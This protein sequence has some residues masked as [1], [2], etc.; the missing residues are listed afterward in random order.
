MSNPGKNLFLSVTRKIR[1]LV[2]P[3]SNLT[4][5]NYSKPNSK[6]PNFQMFPVCRCSLKSIQYN[7]LNHFVW[8]LNLLLTCLS[9]FTHSPV[10]DAPLLYVIVPLPQ[11]VPFFVWPSYLNNLSSF[12]YWMWALETTNSKGILF[13]KQ[14]KS[15][16][17]LLCYH[18]ARGNTYPRTNEFTTPIYDESWANSDKPLFRGQTTS[19]FRQEA[20]H[21]L[22]MLSFA[23]IRIFLS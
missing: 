18:S 15:D 13:A 17:N 4:R 21:K 11:G 16:F 10:Q 1:F 20:E 9:P 14:Q 3:Q 6:E 19:S 5:Q 12:G 8:Q 2:Y 7:Y 22:W 23:S